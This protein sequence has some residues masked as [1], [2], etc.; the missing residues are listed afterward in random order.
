MYG[1]RLYLMLL[2]KNKTYKISLCAVISA[3]SV[4]L[5]LLTGL[6]P[7]ASYA[8]PALAGA[9]LAVI[10]IEAGMKWAI[11]S[12]I[13]VAVLAFF[14]TPDTT[15]KAAYILLFGYYPILKCVIEKVK[16]KPVRWVLKVIN[17]NLAI[18]ASFL[19]TTYV[20]N[21]PD[22]I[23]EFKTAG[24]IVAIAFLAV[25]NIAF[26]LYDILLTRLIAIYFY[27]YRKYFIK[28]R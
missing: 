7:F 22:F 11:L 5:M 23:E 19:I 24:P 10:V 16:L 14:I 27:K 9:L 8:L 1:W 12:Y 15:A 18:V 13:A 3:V 21:L 4:V 20:F 28:N 25:A 17:L 6:F 2:T 26:V